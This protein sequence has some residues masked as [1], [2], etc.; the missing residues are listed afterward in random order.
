MSVETGAAHK[1]WEGSKLGMWIF[2]FTEIVLF[3]GLF[4]LYSAY[5]AKYTADFHSSGQELNTFIG[6]AN[7]VI[8]LTS[9]LTV[10]VS[11]TAL[12]KGNRKLSSICL[13][14]TIALGAVFLINK[15]MEWS[16]EIGHGIG[17]HAYEQPVINRQWSLEHPQEIQEGM[18]IAV[19]GHE[20]DPGRQVVRLEQMAVVTADGP[21]LIDRY[22]TGI[23]PVG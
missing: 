13:A 21:Q 7:T 2:L 20:G 19:E 5:R 22:P 1:D 14:A 15:Y 9:S 11:V 12:Q 4:L 10:A 16:A 17:L 6:I 3:G 18:V 8:L 23:I